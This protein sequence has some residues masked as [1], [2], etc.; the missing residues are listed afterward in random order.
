MKREDWVS[1]SSDAIFCFQPLLVAWKTA[2]DA[3]FD[4]NNDGSVCDF[5][6]SEPHCQEGF[7][8]RSI[9]KSGG[10]LLGLALIATAFLVFMSLSNA[11]ES[12]KCA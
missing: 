7:G 4:T 5:S 2:A 1:E 6:L 9:T 8:G 11:R 3:A 12:F 10:Y